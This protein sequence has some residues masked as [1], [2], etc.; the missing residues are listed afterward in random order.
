MIT[1]NWEN[2]STTLY[3]VLSLG[4]AETEADR[5]NNMFAESWT[6]WLKGENYFTEIMCFSSFQNYIFEVCNDKNGH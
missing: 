6:K 4:I 5:W 1:V 3:V 2:K